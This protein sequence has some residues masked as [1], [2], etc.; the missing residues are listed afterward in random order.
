M[1]IIINKS[2]GV[3][4]ISKKALDLF[5]ER[6]GTEIIDLYVTDLR[7]NPIFIS[8]VEELC[9]ESYGKRS[10]LKVIEIPDDID[11]YIS[12]YDGIESVH[13]NHRIWN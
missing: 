5:Y 10:K 9:E 13:E 1:K 2:F 7:V 3:F 4:D 11:Y 12:D 8:I 6:I